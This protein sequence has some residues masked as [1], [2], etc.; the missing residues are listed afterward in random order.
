MVMEEAEEEG[1]EL[2]DKTATVKKEIAL[3]A[4]AM[5]P[6]ARCEVTRQGRDNRARQAQVVDRLQRRLLALRRTEYLPL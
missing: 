2:E 5:G 1:R 3:E 6:P 4:R